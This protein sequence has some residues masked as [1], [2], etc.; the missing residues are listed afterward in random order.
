MR[1]GE[2]KLTE[3][4]I[5]EVC[6]LFQEGMSAIEL[7]KKFTVHYESIY[8]CLRANN[9]KL[10]K[11]HPKLTELEEQEICRLYVEEGMT[12]PEIGNRFDVNHSTVRSYLKKNKI[13]PRSTRI[14]FTTGQ[15]KE[16]LN[17]YQDGINTTEIGN[18]FGV[19]RGVIIKCLKENKI[20]RRQVGIKLIDEQVSKICQ[21]YLDGRNVIEISTIFDIS[22]RTVSKYLK[23]NEIQLRGNCIKISPGDKFERWTVIEEVKSRRV[24]RGNGWKDIRYFLCECSCP[25]KTRKE[26]SLSGLRIGHSKSCG[27]YNKESASKRKLNS[28][29]DYTGYIFGR[30]TILYEVERSKNKQRQIMAQ[31]SCPDKTIKKY[32]LWNLV[33]GTTN[34][35]GCFQRENT[36]NLKTY[37]AKDYQ[38]KYPLFCQI[39]EIRDKIGEVGIEARCKYCNKWFKPKQ[40]QLDSRIRALEYPEKGSLGTECNLYCSDECKH[41]CILYKLQSDPFKQNEANLNQ[42]T[43]YELAYGEKKTYNVNGTFTVITSA[44]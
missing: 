22:Q 12:T 1:K 36:K 42:P 14:K 6:N 21:L 39:E 43:P 10:R 26:V 41:S 27:C 17:L 33:K 44:P 29:K 16:I 15:E 28:G 11:L 40:K 7:S 4:Q 38:E 35:C 5:L 30:L 25:D 37:S 3:E 9:I 20:K 31:C 8:V 2:R 13:D 34:S 23:E 32:T 18:K 19:S 24:K